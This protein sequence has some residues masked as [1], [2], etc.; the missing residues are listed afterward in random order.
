[1]G[2]VRGSCFKSKV[3]WL[4]DERSNTVSASK[5]ARIFYGTIQNHPCLQKKKEREFQKA[6]HMKMQQSVWAEP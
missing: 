2:K 4:D 3:V 1:M 6:W 5:N